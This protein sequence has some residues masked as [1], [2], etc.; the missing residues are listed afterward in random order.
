MPAA[1]EAARVAFGTARV[2]H[3]QRTDHGGCWVAEA[4]G[5]IVGT[6][7]G[8]IREGLWDFSLFAVM[9]DVQGQGIGTRLYVP[10]TA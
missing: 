2:A 4:D 10:A 5:R 8:L 9:P 1:Q 3:L 6:A 7:I